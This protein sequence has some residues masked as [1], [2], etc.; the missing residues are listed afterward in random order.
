MAEKQRV[1]KTGTSSN[2]GHRRSKLHFQVLNFGTPDQEV[3]SC[4]SSAFPFSPDSVSSTE[5]ALQVTHCCQKLMNKRPRQASSSSLEA[6]CAFCLNRHAR[7]SIHSRTGLYTCD[8]CGTFLV[9]RT[10]RVWY[11]K[12][13]LRFE[14]SKTN[15]Y[16][17]RAKRCKRQPE[18]VF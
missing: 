5:R 13:H 17:V 7:F 12:D 11:R 2:P 3:R 1:S 8:F 4:F 14:P 18:R 6:T 16:T 9:Y 10:W 15:S